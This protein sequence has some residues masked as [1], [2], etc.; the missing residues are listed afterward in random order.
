[1]LKGFR[2]R[3]SF[4]IAPGV[5]LNLSKGGLSTSVG[6]AGAILNIGRKGN[7]ATVGLPGTGASYQREFKSGKWFYYILTGAVLLY[8]AYNIISAH[9]GHE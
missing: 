9:F 7:K 4:N 3:K 5:K 2:F 8:L 1:M 6:K